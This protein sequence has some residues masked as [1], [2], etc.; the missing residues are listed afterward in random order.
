MNYLGS[1]ATFFLVYSVLMFPMYYLPY[2]GSNSAIGGLTGAAPQEAAVN[3]AFWPHLAALLIL[4][5]ITWFRGALLNRRWLVVFPV[6]AS[7]FDLAPDQS[8]VPLIPVV[9]HILAILLGTPA[10]SSH[11]R[12]SV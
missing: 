1:T 2:H 6:L 8:F 9:L 3:P 11:E 7:I 4:V 5:T 10:S 12:Q